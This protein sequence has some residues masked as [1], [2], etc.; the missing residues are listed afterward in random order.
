[1]TGGSASK[2]GDDDNQCIHCG[3]W[4]A[5]AGVQSHEANCDWQSTDRRM[6]DLVDPLAIMRADDVDVDDIE[7]ADV[8]PDPPGATP[9]GDPGGTP[10][11]DPDIGDSA[12]ETRADGGPSSV[13]TDFDD[14][15]DG[16]DAGG[17]DSDPDPDGCPECGGDWSMPVAEL[18]DEVLEAAPDLREYDKLCV[19]CSTDDEGNLT[20]EAV[21]Y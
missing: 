13:P 7:E 11:E 6:H 2:E 21:V 16:G 9:G 18:P 20:D 3:R 4:Y 10:M 1:M 5:R 12:S 19:P 15:Q 14:V 8:D 17:S